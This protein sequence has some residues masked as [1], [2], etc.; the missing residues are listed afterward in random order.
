MEEETGELTKKSKEISRS[1]VI[2]NQEKLNQD[3]AMN[4]FYFQVN[5]HYKKQNK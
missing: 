4:S 3:K 1:F 5:F 2:Q